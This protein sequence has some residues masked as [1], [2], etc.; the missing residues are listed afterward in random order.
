M[1]RYR[2]RCLIRLLTVRNPAYTLPGGDPK[3][4]ETIASRAILIFWKEPMI[5]ILLNNQLV[6]ERTWVERDALTYP[7]ERCVSG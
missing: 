4:S 7:R 6:K 1:R 5:W 2:A 3:I